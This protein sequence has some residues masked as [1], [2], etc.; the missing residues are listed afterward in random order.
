MMMMM[1]MMMMMNHLVSVAWLGRGDP[2][3]SLSGQVEVTRRA[4]HLTGIRQAVRVI[5]STDRRLTQSLGQLRC[6]TQLVLGRRRWAEVGTR[7]VLS[8]KRHAPRLY[9]VGH[10]AQLN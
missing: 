8:P 4:F 3:Q 6:V 5:Q 10:A 9:Q 7:S 1:M 2:E